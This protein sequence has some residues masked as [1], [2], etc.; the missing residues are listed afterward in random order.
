MKIEEIFLLMLAVMACCLGNI[1][2]EEAERKWKLIS[3]LEEV[4]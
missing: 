4:K 1:S 3:K 2:P